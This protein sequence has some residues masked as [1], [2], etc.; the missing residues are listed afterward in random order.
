[1]TVRHDGLLVNW[2]GYATVRIEGS[3]AVVYLDPGRY[4]VLDGFEPRDGDVVCV[5]HD[6]HYDSEGIR[7]VA[8]DD[9]TVLV[10]EAVD[11]AGI[12]RDVEPVEDLPFAVDRVTDG[13]SLSVRGVRVE[14][15]P[16]YNDPDG[17][18]VRAD[19][20]PVHPEGFGIGYRVAVDGVPAFWP[21][22]SDVL[23]LHDEVSA[24]LLLPPI[25]GSFTMDREAAAALAE[26]MDP[27]LTLPVHYDTFEALEADAG[28]FAADVAGRGVPVVLDEGPPFGQ[29]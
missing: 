21:G 3:D 1:M 19:G 23:D 5:T 25:G 29:A 6:H 18:H 17:P 27:D 22:D 14:T 13:E 16:A 10:Y 26:R 15:Y 4:G 2:Y 7:R 28:A 9:A 20:S 12:D 8:A 24:S 11:P